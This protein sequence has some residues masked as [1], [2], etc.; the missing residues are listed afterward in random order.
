M[1][2]YIVVEGIK[3]YAP[4]LAGQNDG[5]DK[6]EFELLF[7]AEENSFWFKIRNKIIKYLFTKYSNQEK[8]TK[9]LEIGCGTGFVLQALSDLKNV[10]LT[11]SEIYLEGL[12][13]ARKRLSS[14]ELIQ[15]DATNMPFVNA[16]DVIGAFDVMEH[17]AEDEKVMEMVHKALVEHGVFMM[18]VPQYP[19]M[20]SAQD[21][22]AFHK[23]RYT[24]NELS[25]K[26]K[27]HGFEIQ[28]LGSFVFTLFP[29]MVISRIIKRKENKNVMSEFEIPRILNW[30]FY[31][32]M[33]AD[34]ILIRIGFSLPF[35]GSLVCVAGKKSKN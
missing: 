9:L 23:R 10:D 31:A 19:W 16:F 26:L 14:V 11:G 25:T 5:F 22:Y 24:R 12:F 3:C 27:K 34:F 15:L 28:Y 6:S 32:F 1:N 4:S 30:I 20:W 13:F 7:E 33:Y 18:T 35:G 29:V 17:I 21:E 2:D 8:R